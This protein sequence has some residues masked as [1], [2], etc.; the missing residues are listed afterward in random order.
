MIF[1][2]IFDSS[3]F[4][5]VKTGSPPAYLQRSEGTQV[6][7]QIR[8]TDDLGCD[9]SLAEASADLRRQTI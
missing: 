5:A 6:L 7:R 3:G 2:Y 9:I 8:R 1:V 4:M